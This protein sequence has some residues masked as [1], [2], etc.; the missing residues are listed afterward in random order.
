[1]KE[2]LIMQANTQ[3]PGRPRVLLADDNRDMQNVII[4]L[5]EPEFD[6]V[7]TV[8]NGFELVEA[9]S[10]LHP[11]IGI[12]DISMPV[13]NGIEAA[14]EIKKNGSLMKIIF[15]T[16]NEDS[17]FVRAAFETGASG[18]VIKR[19][20]GADLI[21]AIKQVLAGGMFVPVGYEIIGN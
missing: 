1:M 14:A 7:G 9:E 6:V 19:Q 3:N 5:L 10:R 2:G 12:I 21:G 16:V 20:M 18:Y 11:N 4:S 8:A 17:D 13:M 15:L